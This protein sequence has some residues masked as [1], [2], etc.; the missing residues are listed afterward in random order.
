MRRAA[1]PV[2]V[3]PHVPVAAP[4][5]AGALAFRPAQLSAALDYADQAQAPVTARAYAADWR[6][7]AAWCA[8]RDLTPLPAAP[9]TVACSSLTRRARA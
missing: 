9:A 3:V 6:T 8:V 4:A 2:P 5:A 1:L 7:F